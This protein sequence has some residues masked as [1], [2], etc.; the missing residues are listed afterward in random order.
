MFEPDDDV[1]VVAFNKAVASYR[2]TM[3]KRERPEE[4][5]GGPHQES[6]GSSSKKSKKKKKKASRIQQVV[7]VEEPPVVM[8]RIVDAPIEHG[9][10]NVENQTSRQSAIP[11]GYTGYIYP[12]PAP[13]EMQ[14]IAKYGSLI[15]RAQI[16]PFL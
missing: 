6:G 8:G 3:N 15:F 13:E 14:V 1:L 7:L 9:S 10:G 11:E 2:E 5:A 16:S 12:P 4:E